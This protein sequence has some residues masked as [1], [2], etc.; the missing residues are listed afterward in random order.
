MKAK[1][2]TRY[3]EVFRVFEDGDIALQWCEDRLLDRVL[4]PLPEMSIGADNYEL[5]NGFSPDELIILRKFFERRE[6]Q[7]GQ[8]I[9]NP[10]EP[11]RDLYLLARGRVSVHLPLEDGIT[12][13]L[14]VFTAG[15][16]FGE[17]GVLER[18]PH[19]SQIVADTYTACDLLSMAKLIAIGVTHPKIKIRLLENLAFG[20]CSKLRKAN[21]ESSLLV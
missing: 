4:P 3:E 11:A 6:W 12:K 21:R 17:M 15:M 19:T 13:R 18:V 9:C 7:A 10:G 20:L 14:A 2:A 16:T 5:L 1:L 8:T